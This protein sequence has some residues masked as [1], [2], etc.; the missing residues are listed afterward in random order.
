MSGQKTIFAT[1]NT[2]SVRS[3]DEEGVG[4]LRWEDGKCYKWVENAITNFTPGPADWVCHDFTNGALAETKIIKP[5]TAVLGY[6]AGQACTTISA[7]TGTNP[8]RYGWIQIYGMTTVTVTPVNTQT[9]SNPVAGNFLIAVN[10]VQTYLTS[11]Q[12]MGTAPIYS[13]GVICNEP[14]IGSTAAQNVKGFIRCL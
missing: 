12:A 5:A 8:L 7:S 3:T 4:R 10:G 6:L 13:R 9:T 14:V 2:T 11:G 1:P